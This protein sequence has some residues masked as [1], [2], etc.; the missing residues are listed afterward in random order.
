MKRFKPHNPET[1]RHISMSA[2]EGSRVYLNDSE[3]S[4]MIPAAFMSINLSTI[5]ELLK[6]EH[7]DLRRRFEYVS[8]ILTI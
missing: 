2:P 3:K 1:A 8:P 6:Q 4:A 7:Y 5:D